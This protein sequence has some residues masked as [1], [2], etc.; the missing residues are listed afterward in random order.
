M[1]PHWTQTQTPLIPQ[2]HIPLPSAP[3][4]LYIHIPFCRKACHYC[5]FYFS[6]RHSLMEDFTHALL[7]E[8]HTWEPW[9]L[10]QPVR[11]VY[12][13]GGTP[14]WLRPHLLEKILTT[15]PKHTAWHPVEITLE[16]NPEN[17]TPENLAFWKDLGIN[18]MSLGVQS[19]SDEILQLLG[20]KVSA[21]LT[22][23]AIEQI[24]ASGWTNWS[25][26]VIFAVPGQTI[27]DIANDLYYLVNEMQV[28]HIS[29]YGLTIEPR[30]VL[31]KKHLQGRFESIDDEEYAKM[32]LFVHDFLGAYGYDHYEVS[33][34]AKSDFYSRHNL[35]Y[36]EG[37]PYIGLGPSAHSYIFP[38]RWWNQADLR[39][40]VAYFG[41]KQRA[42]LQVEGEHLSE[43]A[44]LLEWFMLRFRLSREIRWAEFPLREESMRTL[45]ERM[46]AWVERGWVEGTRGGMR[47][48]PLGWLWLNAI[49]REVWALISYAG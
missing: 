6:V 20:R 33:N 40:Y 12:F 14:S 24:R 10:S 30:T 31:Y 32:Y 15:L 43:G 21:T 35:I 11:T 16:A 4:G 13:G 1:L 22:R 47:M 27:Q 7:E 3:I 9:L 44:A 26:D 18:R 23:K 46:Q 49:L 28:P 17:I 39:G 36:W 29:L 42:S 38:Y 37:G 48:L 34:W 2:T 45:Q 25:V 19:L 8:I 5:D 41:K